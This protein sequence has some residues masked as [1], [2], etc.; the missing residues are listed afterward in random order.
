MRGLGV[1]KPADN[2]IL[3]MNPAAEA[4]AAEA[5]PCY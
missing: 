3:S 2:L 1:N 4:A 5:K